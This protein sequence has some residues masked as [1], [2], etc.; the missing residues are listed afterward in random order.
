MLG[1]PWVKPVPTGCSIQMTLVLLLS[2]SRALGGGV[3]WR[4]YKFV[5][6]YVFRTG[7]KV[8]CCHKKG[9]FSVI[10]PLRELQPGPPFNLSSSRQHKSGLTQRRNSPDHKLIITCIG[11]AAG[12]EP[13]EQFP[14]LSRR[15]R[16]WQQTS[17]RLADIEVDIWNSRAIDNKPLGILVEKPRSRGFTFLGCRSP[18][19]GGEIALFGPGQVPMVQSCPGPVTRGCLS[20]SPKGKEAEQRCESHR[21]YCGMAGKEIGKDVG[22]LRHFINIFCSILIRLHFCL[23]YVIYDDR[24]HM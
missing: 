14:A 18:W 7:K 1:V 10:R 21:E 17:I 9:P 4:S 16:D 8:P 22:D 2:V 5:Q 12:E 13:E 23:R 3:I 11:I 15:F 6:L 24:V 20:H 19:A